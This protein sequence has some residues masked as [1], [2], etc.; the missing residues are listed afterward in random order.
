MLYA[1]EAAYET[2]E[3]IVLKKFDIS[4]H[5]LEY[6]IVKNVS[7][8]QSLVRIRHSLEKGI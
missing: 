6:L 1:L 5:S 8:D 4:I 3:E 7:S 2:Q